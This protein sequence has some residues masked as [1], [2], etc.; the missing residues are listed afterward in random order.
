MRIAST[1]ELQFINRTGAGVNG[2]GFIPLA[3]TFVQQ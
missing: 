3:F 2:G 1:G